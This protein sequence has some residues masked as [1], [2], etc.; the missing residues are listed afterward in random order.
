MVRP[1][2]LLG[3]ASLISGIVVGGIGGRVVM[4][5]SAR[6]AGEEMIGRVT[7]NGN[8]VGEF[9]VG[10]T[11]ALIVFVGLLGGMLASVAVVASDP[12]LRWLGP[13]RGIGFGLVVLAV[14]GYDTFASIDF[15]ILDP[16]SLNVAMFLALIIGF[17]LAVVGF[18][19][20]LDRKLPGPTDREQMGWI[21]VVGLGAMPLLMTVLFFTSESFCGCDPAYGI[22]VSLMIMILATVAFHV[23][24]GTPLIP[25]W[26]KRVAMIAGYLSL[27]AAVSLGM[28]RTIDNLQQL[29]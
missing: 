23:E 29:F 16:V 20:L 26:G 24:S 13:F 22:G 12:W 11:I 10:G 5:V 25:V 15:L 21:I 27:A 1:I 7:E 6:A 2:A 9:T 28:L 17:G 4:S 19:R 18:Q 8:V 3:L 14:F